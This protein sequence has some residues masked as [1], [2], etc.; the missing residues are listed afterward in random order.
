MKK[1][2]LITILF[3]GFIPNS[4]KADTYLIYQ[5]YNCQEFQTHLAF[6]DDGSLIILTNDGV[7]RG[8]YEQYGIFFKAECSG[9]NEQGNFAC[10]SYIGFFMQPFIFGLENDYLTCDSKITVFRTR[11]WG[12]LLY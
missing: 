7:S 4:L 3:L 9:F 6:E 5:R 10:W 12:Y 8:N 11:F 2:L 1:I